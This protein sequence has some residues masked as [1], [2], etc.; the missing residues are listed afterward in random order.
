M[1]I[2]ARKIGAELQQNEKPQ[3][4]PLRSAGGLNVAV[5]SSKYLIWLRSKM[6]WCPE[7]D[8]N[9]HTLSSTST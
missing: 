8:S 7:E 4:L 2:F 3:H 5:F 1:G 6:E 9:L